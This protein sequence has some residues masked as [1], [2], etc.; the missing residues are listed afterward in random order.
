ME[1]DQ[2]RQVYLR[3]Y[4][5]GDSLAASLRD[6]NVGRSTFYEWRASH[7][8]LDEGIREEARAQ[9]LAEVEEDRVRSARLRERIQLELLASVSPLLESLARDAS[10]ADSVH[11]RIAAL[12]ELRQW[13]SDNA[14]RPP[15]SAAEDTPQLPASASIALPDFLSGGLSRLEVEAVSGDKITMEKG[16]VF[17]S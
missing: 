6:Q 3:L 2:V 13:L 4:R 5:D 8:D 11:T 10:E 14:L 9:A 15:L 17:E 1:L 7:P 12:R 16:Q